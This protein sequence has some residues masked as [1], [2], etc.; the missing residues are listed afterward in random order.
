MPIL[1]ALIA[2]TALLVVTIGVGGY[3]RWRQNRPRRHIAHEV[4]DP[5]RLGADG[6][7]AEATLLQFSTELCA[8][9]PH[10]HRTLAAVAD[11]RQGVRH[12]DVDLT[13]RPDI[14]RHFHVL[15]TPTTLIL[16]R[17]GVVQTRFGG[18]PG[19]DVIELELARLT[20]EPARA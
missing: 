15:Q 11:S 12:L 10:V 7:G 16:D 6:L 18:V 14:A 2:I 8:R 17:D 4:V 3:L 9:C 5:S 13:H 1:E 20:G 19:R